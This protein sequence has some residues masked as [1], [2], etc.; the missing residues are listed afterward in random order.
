ML[1]PDESFLAH[2][3]PISIDGS[4]NTREKEMLLNAL[5]FWFGPAQGWG[6]VQNVTDANSLNQ[7]NVTLRQPGER[8]DLLELQT[9]LPT[10]YF[11]SNQPAVTQVQI[12]AAKRD[13]VGLPPTYFLYEAFHNLT[14]YIGPDFLHNIP[15]HI[16]INT[17]VLDAQH[18]PRQSYT[19]RF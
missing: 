11:A 3:L 8:Y 5:R 6:T 19:L 4:P 13:N 10:G 7:L 12:Y 17:L 15:N 14:F 1:P 9:S 18:I 2:L 16:V